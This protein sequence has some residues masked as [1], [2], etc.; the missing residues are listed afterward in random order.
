MP[1]HAAALAPL[2][3]RAAISSSTVGDAKTTG[4][5]TGVPADV[6]QDA[7]ETDAGAAA[8]SEEETDV[9]AAETN[10]GAVK[11]KLAGARDGVAG[12]ELATEEAT[13][14]RLLPPPPLPPPSPM[15]DLGLGSFDV[16]GFL[17]GWP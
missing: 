6:A 13:L 16:R 12:P 4:S 2:A 8:N 7:A 15:L 1:P 9:G 5:C 17:A 11:G 3:A 10:V 14:A